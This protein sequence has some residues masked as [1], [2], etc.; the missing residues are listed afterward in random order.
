M[1]PKPL[2]EMTQDEI[3]SEVMAMRNLRVNGQKLGAALREG[4][5]REAAKPPVKK[6]ASINDVL[7]S[8]GL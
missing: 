7:G 1:S 4:A 2:H 5:A 6:V 3:R 8:L